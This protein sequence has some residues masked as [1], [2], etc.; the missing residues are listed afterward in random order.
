MLA[1][2]ES[3]KMG[4]LRAWALLLM[5][6]SGGV[7]FFAHVILTRADAAGVRASDLNIAQDIQ[8]VAVGGFL[9]GIAL[10]V[11]AIIRRR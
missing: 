9:V 11:A 1:Q 7:A 6:I 8:F 3:G 10:L 5:V 2:G 4:E